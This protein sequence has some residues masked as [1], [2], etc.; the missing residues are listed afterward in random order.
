LKLGGEGEGVWV[1]SW[2]ILRTDRGRSGVWGK[3]I[4]KKPHCRGQFLGLGFIPSKTS[5][6]GFFGWCTGGCCVTQALCPATFSILDTKM[7]IATIISDNESHLFSRF[8][9]IWCSLWISLE[10]IF[11]WA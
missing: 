3:R 11:N 9:I 10:I 8:S 7:Y 1:G 4:E 2:V 5:E 6:M